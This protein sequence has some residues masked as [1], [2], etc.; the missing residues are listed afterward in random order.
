MILYESLMIL[1][2]SILQL[3]GFADFIDFYGK[4]I[5]WSSPDWMIGCIVEWG[6]R[7]LGYR[8]LFFVYFSLIHI[9]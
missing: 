6:V 3:V 5:S 8:T 9:S 2:D 7:M 1:Y 4:V